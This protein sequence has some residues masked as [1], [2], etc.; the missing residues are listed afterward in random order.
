MEAEAGEARALADRT[1]HLRIQARAGA[2]GSLPGRHEAACMR[3]SH[4]ARDE[5]GALRR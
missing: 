2:R 4:F 3:V 5:G 1:Q